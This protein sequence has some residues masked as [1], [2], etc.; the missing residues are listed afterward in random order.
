MD[1]CT[2]TLAG[3]LT[4]LVA[5]R[6]H[7]AAVSIEGLLQHAIDHLPRRPIADGGQPGQRP[8]R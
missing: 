2:A 8:W 5:A 6:V 7:S 1:L 3:S 4:S